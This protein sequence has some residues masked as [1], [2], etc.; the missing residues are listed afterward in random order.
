MS[1]NSYLQDLSSNLVLSSNEKSGINYI[2]NNIFSL[3]H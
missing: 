3:V 2:S 1:I